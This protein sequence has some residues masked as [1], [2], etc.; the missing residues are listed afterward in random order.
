MWSVRSV[1]RRRHGPDHQPAVAGVG[2][3]DEPGRAAAGQAGP[4]TGRLAEAVAPG[5]P[6]SGSTARAAGSRSLPC[7]PCGAAEPVPGPVHGHRR[8]AERRDQQR[9]ALRRRCAS[10]SSRSPMPRHPGPPVAQAERHV[11]PEAGRRHRVLA[12]HPSA[13]RRRRRPTRRPARP[14][15]GSAWSATPRR[16]VRRSRNARATRLSS[17]GRR[18]RPRRSEA[19]GSRTAADATRRRRRTGADTASERDQVSARS[20]LTISASIR[21]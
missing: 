7:A 3:G 4:L 13:A 6:V 15:P 5:R 21:W 1:R 19:G 16:R 17:P 11:G 12:A 2:A 8:A 14:R 20:R 10:G 18:R 9:V